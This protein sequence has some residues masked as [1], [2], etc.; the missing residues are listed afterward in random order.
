MA[1]PM[2]YKF[3]LFVG[4]LLARIIIHSNANAQTKDSL[5]QSG[6]MQ[7]QQFSQDDSISKATDTSLARQD[8][9][10]NLDISKWK[11][12]REF[13]YMHF[14]DSLLRN[15]KNMQIDTVSV[16]EKSGIIKRKKSHLNQPS[17]LNNRLNS[18][19]LKIFFWALAIFFILFVSYKVFFK[20]GIFV[21]KKEIRSGDEEESIEELN[22]L[23]KYD[24]LAYDAENKNEFNLA[25]RYLFL[26]T[27]KNLSDKGFIHFTSEKT[28]K[29]YLN[30][31]RQHY[32]FDQFR[33]L[34]RDYE[35]IW[36]GKF[37]ID[38]E[39]YQQLKEDF[40]FFNKKV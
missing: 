24:S 18:W 26:K 33:N 28:N 25:T 39:R 38:E 30:E 13:A 29:D 2:K 14:L 31:M 34:T 16:D 12:T 35:Y 21:R 11:K 1:L 3:Y 15:E 7:T 37:S 22:E 27:L 8:L 4:L 5:T 6:K 23:S 19:P 20:N 9:K 36:Y 17:S 32:Y 10:D 40:S